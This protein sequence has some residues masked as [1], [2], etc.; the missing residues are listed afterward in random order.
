[1]VS[2]ACGLP[3]SLSQHQGVDSLLLVKKNGGGILGETGA[4]L[5]KRTKSSLHFQL[6]EEKRAFLKKKKK[7]KRERA[8]RNWKLYWLAT[9][10]LGS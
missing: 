3:L 1:M 7:G 5:P 4:G 6:E 9:F 8:E 10:F 2:H